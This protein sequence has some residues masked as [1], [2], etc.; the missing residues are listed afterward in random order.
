LGNRVVVEVRADLHQE[1]R[2]LAA[3]YDARLYVVVNLLLE[4]C[5]SD[6]ERVAAVLSKLASE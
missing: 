2:K 4:D 6:K 1:L 5:L 3:L